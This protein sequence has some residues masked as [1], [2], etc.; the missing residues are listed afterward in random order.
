MEYS[1][2]AQARLKVRNIKGDEV[3]RVLLSPQELYF[4]VVTGNLVAIGRRAFRSHHWLIVVYTR[5]NE[6]YRVIT[7]IDAKSLDRII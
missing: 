3:E 1:S 6:V 7:I 5:Y 2:H 4:D